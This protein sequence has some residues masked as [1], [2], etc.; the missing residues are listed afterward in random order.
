MIAIGIIY[1]VCQICITPFTQLLTDQTHLLILLRGIPVV[2]HQ[3]RRA[4]V[5][6]VIPHSSSVSIDTISH[7][8]ILPTKLILTF[9]EETTLRLHLILLRTAL[10][11]IIYRLPLASYT[12]LKNQLLVVCHLRRYLLPV[13]I[14][15]HKVLI[16]LQFLLK[17]GNIHLHH[18]H[19]SRRNG[20]RH[21]DGQSVGSMH[22]CNQQKHKN[23]N[24]DL[25]HIR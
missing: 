2:E 22:R 20:V 4:L 19:P 7:T 16:C 15:H 14:R 24:V 1:L 6:E 10:L 13:C 8:V 17:N 3:V 9:C 21:S 18:L 11:H 25:F 12:H 5:E 23:Q